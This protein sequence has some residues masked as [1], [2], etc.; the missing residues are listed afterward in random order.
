MVL[1]MVG[2]PPPC[3]LYHAVYICGKWQ[4]AAATTDPIEVILTHGVPSQQGVRVGL[5]RRSKAS[6]I[7][8]AKLNNKQ[9]RRIR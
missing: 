1:A 7:R 9:E 5:G 6:N 4:Q 2:Q 8:E 3:L